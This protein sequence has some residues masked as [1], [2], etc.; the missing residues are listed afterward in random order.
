[1]GISEIWKGTKWGEKINLKVKEV[2]LLDINDYYKAVTIKI[3]WWWYNDR[4]IDQWKKKSTE[5]D[6]C[7][8]R[9]W[10]APA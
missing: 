3:L 1:M 7:L 2:A 8:Y 5:T 9:H 4:Q 6:P 10:G